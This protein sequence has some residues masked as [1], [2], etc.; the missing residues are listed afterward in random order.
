MFI[1]LKNSSYSKETISDPLDRVGTVSFSSDKIHDLMAQ[2][3]DIDRMTEGSF[4]EIGRQVKRFH[5]KANH[6][7]TEAAHAMQLLEGETGEQNLIKLQLLVERCS[8]WLD[9]ALVQTTRIVATLEQ[10][11]SQV[12]KMKAPLQGLGKL[13]KTLQGLRISTRIETVRVPGSGAQVLAED[14]KRL[15]DL[16]QSKVHQI[17]SQFGTIGSLSC[18]MLKHQQQV[19][20]GPLR[21]AKIGIQEN[22]LLLSDLLGQRLETGQKTEKL[23]QESDKIATHFA[24]IIMAL[25][26]QDITR[27]RLEHIQHALED[28]TVQID[29]EHTQSSGLSSIEASS[30]TGEVCSLQR[31]HLEEAAAEFNVAV[32]SLTRNL[33]DMVDSVRI[34]STD[35]NRFVQNRET[36]FDGEQMTGTLLLQAVTDQLETV[37]EKHSDASSTIQT[38]CA[39]V[40]EISEQIDAIEYI[41]EEMQLMA[42]NAAINAA[43]CRGK[44]AGLQVIAGQIQT[45]AEGAFA[46]TLALAEECRL[47][48]DHADGLIQ[49]DD[50]GKQ[51]ETRLTELVEDGRVMFQVL[52]GNRQEFTDLLQGVSRET[53]LLEED[54]T[55]CRAAIVIRENFQ[56]A[57]SPLLD[58]LSE[59]ARFASGR[60]DEQSEVRSDLFSK[61]HARYTMQR[62]RVIHNGLDGFQRAALQSNRAVVNDDMTTHDL[63]DNVE[64]F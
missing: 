46:G 2:F 45:L 38:V 44:G 5:Q 39:Q 51:L 43:H 40:S 37:L 21:I 15:T 57:I 36:A 23:K 4:L 6:I 62:E 48:A 55:A 14:L 32:D 64:L 25:Q 7:S 28:L 53:D 3:A 61:I 60:S 24:E 52:Q 19:G 17:E 26:F 33:A 30:L 20:D 47:V 9:D 58:G 31:E 59:M 50:V 16:I 22:R 13:I 11:V 63:G 12:A 42:F 49:L 10:I 34:L 29:V 8:L 54:V 1:D 41:G 27:Q 35:T 56:T 18:K